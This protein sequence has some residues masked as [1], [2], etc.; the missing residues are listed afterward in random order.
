[1]KRVEIKSVSVGKPTKPPTGQAA[2]HGGDCHWT[3]DGGV[4]DIKMSD[5]QP[6]NMVTF[7]HLTIPCISAWS[8]PPVHFLHDGVDMK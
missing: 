7:S 6:M 5:D 1:M 4:V 2:Y 8:R 3:V